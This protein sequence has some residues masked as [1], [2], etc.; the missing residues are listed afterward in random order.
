[1]FSII[2]FVSIHIAKLKSTCYCC[3]VAKKI[4]FQFLHHHHISSIQSLRSF[5][6]YHLWI[7][8]ENLFDF[9]LCMPTTYLRYSFLVEDFKALINGAKAINKKSTLRGFKVKF[10]IEIFYRISRKNCLFYNSLG[11]FRKK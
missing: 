9:F 1:M 11:I 3:S 2:S 4:C 10:F 6:F 8:I 7:S 5:E